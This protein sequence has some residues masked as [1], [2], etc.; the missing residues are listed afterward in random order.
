MFTEIVAFLV[1]LNPFAMFLYLGPVMRELSNKSFVKVFQNK[2]MGLWGEQN[3][4][5]PK[6]VNSNKKKAVIKGLFDNGFL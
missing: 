4:I 3:F 5:A 2:L 1:L 6:R